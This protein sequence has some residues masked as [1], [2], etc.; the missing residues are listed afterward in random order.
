MGRITTTTR[1]KQVMSNLGFGTRKL[2]SQ[3]EAS[4]IES[5]DVPRST[6][7]GSWSHKTTFNVSELIPFLVEE[8]LPGDHMRYDVTAYVRMATPLFPVF[9]NFQIDTFFF[10]GGCRLV[11]EDFEKFMGDLPPTGETPDDYSVPQLVSEV[12]GFNPFSLMDYFGIPI[13]PQTEVG[14][15]ISVN[16]LPFRLYNL[17]MNEWFRD[18]NIVVKNEV[19]LGPGPDTPGD[20]AVMPR[21]KAHDYFTSALPWPQKFVAPTLA[22]GGLAPVTGLAIDTARVATAGDPGGRETDGSLTTAWPGYY[23]ASAAANLYVE[24]SAAAAVGSPMIFADL[25]AA[26]GITINQLREAFLVQQLLERDA[27][28]GTRYTEKV[29]GHFKV[30]SP[31]MRLQRPEYIGGGSSPFAISPIAQ[32]APN[33]TPGGVGALGGTGLG[34]ASHSAS[35]A[36]TEHGYIIGLINIRS[37]LLYQQGLHRMWTR[38]SQH[39]FYVPSLAGLGEQAILRKEIFSNGVVA[40]DNMVFGYQESWGDLRQRY[41]FTSGYFRSTDANAIDEW[42]TGQLFAVAPVLDQGFIQDNPPMSRILAGGDLEVGK[43][44]IADIFIRRKATRP[45]PTF[46]TPV[47]LG[48]F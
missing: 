10:F 16:A 25:G 1:R 8:I 6:F 32:T 36:A 2:V 19:P 22:L 5:P 39:D 15:T 30:R 41:S 28:S 12:D 38:T 42:H 24:A 18:Q 40:E 29:F 14:E 23:D 31:D 20:Y 33:A 35:Y 9:S 7:L 46:G 4:M 45:L 17:I 21:M 37:E 44:F 26:S 27:R 3:E 13:K 34:V 11:W 47:A 43:Q 48:R